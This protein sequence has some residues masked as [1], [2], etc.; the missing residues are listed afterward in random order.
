MSI[1]IQCLTKEPVLSEKFLFRLSDVLGQLAAEEKLSAGEVSIV[2]T[3]DQM[4]QRLNLEYREKDTPTDVLSFNYLEP[5]EVHGLA[6][7]EFA[8]GDIYIS[9][10]RASDQACGAGHSIERELALLAIHG[11]LHLIG[12]DHG[13]EAEAREMQKKEQLT[14]EAFEQSLAGDE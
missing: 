10:D 8:V 6:D 9:V 14:L 11:L 5:G 2:F 13:S 3:D 12:Y 4:L 1:N 7:D